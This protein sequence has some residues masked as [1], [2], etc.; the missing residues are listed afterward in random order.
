MGGSA[1]G[2]IDAWAH[3]RLGAWAHGRI[4]SIELTGGVRRL[5]RVVGVLPPWGM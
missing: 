2:R 3:G 1:H 5:D 4:D